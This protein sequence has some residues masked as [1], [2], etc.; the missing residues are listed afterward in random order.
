VTHA[1]P[2]E[3]VQEQH[4]TVHKVE[5]LVGMPTFN[6]ASTAEPVV[7]A[8]V[9]GLE[10]SFARKSILVVDVDAGSQDGTQEIIKNTIG[11]LFPVALVHATGGMS[12]SPFALQRLSD[13]GMPA[14]EEAF[15]SLFTISE[16]LKANACVVIDANLRSVTPEWIERLAQPVL[17]KGADYVAPV[18]RRQRYE[19]SLTNG[20]IAPL[21]RALYGK[22]MACQS[23]G[24]YAFSGKMASLYLQRDVWEGDAA[25]FGIDSWLTT[26][27]VAEG[28]NVW[29]AF[30]TAKVQDMRATGVDV[31][32]VLAQTVG[33]SYHYMERYQDVW[34]KQTGSDPVPAI[35]PPH[36]PSSE[37]VA[38]NV[39]RMV[40]GFRQ[41][42]R[43]LLP[44]WEMILAPDTL[45][46][47]LTLGLSD[48]DGFRFPLPL[49]V[50]TVYDF[51]IAYHEKVIH[52]EHLLKSLTPLYLG[53]TA[54]LVL[55]TQDGGSDKVEQTIE[56]V[57][58]TFERMKPYLVGRWR[59]Q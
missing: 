7:K 51:A 46:G 11:S 32:K 24:G 41:G 9:A 39:E 28:C 12:A 3:Q 20:L 8:I 43:D 6:H 25:R 59:F 34:E 10:A 22:R 30:L 45:A 56:R 49:W 50:Q 38:I 4:P 18:F 29:Q 23:G 40:T 16:A 54:S 53:W 27:A 55:E 37:S 52:R 26:V 48:E 19:G 57:C 33:A 31:S 44:I 5:L 21:T 13:S 14:R 15:Q 17:D 58:E 1:S 42:L 47:I 2:W 36:E 35:G